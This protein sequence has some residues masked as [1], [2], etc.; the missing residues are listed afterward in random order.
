MPS[1]RT[2]SLTSLPTFR[3]SVSLPPK[4]LIWACSR[5]ISTTC[6]RDRC[7]KSR[8][9][10]DPSFTA[11]G[12]TPQ[13]VAMMSAVVSGRSS[14]SRLLMLSST[15]ATSSSVMPIVGSLTGVSVVP[16]QVRLPIG[17]TK[18]RRPSSAKN[19]RTRRSLDQTVDNQMDALRERVVVFRFLARQQIVRINVGAGGIDQ[20]PG[21]DLEF[22]P[23]DDV[24]GT[25]NPRIPFAPRTERLDI[26]GGDAAA[27]Q[28][29]A[30]EVEDETR[31][32]VV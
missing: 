10:P 31:V 1:E 6:L 16:M 2:N 30:H 9:P 17:I 18:N 32:I 13:R 29:G 27:I 5:R 14:F 3:Q 7:R 25:R 19:A 11:S 21:A 26:V 15:K 28:C 20:C 23:V 8:P 24:A 12:R 4:M 22:G